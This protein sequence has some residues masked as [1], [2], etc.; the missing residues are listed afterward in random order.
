MSDD[1]ENEVIT[2]DEARKWVEEWLPKLE[3]NGKARRDLVET[4]L[5]N[6]YELFVENAKLNNSISKA[7]KALAYLA[8]NVL[9]V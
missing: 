4:I 7:K 3:I 9:D 2:Q 8:E 5:D 1:V 6:I